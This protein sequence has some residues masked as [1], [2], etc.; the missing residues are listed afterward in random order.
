MANGKRGGLLL[1]A[2][3]AGC[4]STPHGEAPRAH[5]APAR[6]ASSV[7]PTPAGGIG[8]AAQGLAPDELQRVV[9]GRAGA[10]QA[11]FEIGQ[12]DGYGPPQMVVV[13]FEVGVNGDV[14]AS[15]LASSSAAY[16]RVDSCIVR[17]VK[18]MKFPSA[19]RPTKARFPFAFAAPTE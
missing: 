7:D 9:L 13:D 12:K 16:P 11:C 18:R 5:A 3:L 17:A 19:T 2:L 10:I 14:T 4:A 15:E 6:S 1:A 8:E